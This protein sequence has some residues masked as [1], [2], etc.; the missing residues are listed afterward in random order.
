MK[1]V[2]SASD[3]ARV[4][5]AQS[6]L[7]AAGIAYELR[8]EAISQAIPGMPFTTELWVLRDE[9]YQDALLLVSPGSVPPLGRP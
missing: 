9:D 2:F 1:Q 6:V 3:S 4:G 5:L 7:D 8:N